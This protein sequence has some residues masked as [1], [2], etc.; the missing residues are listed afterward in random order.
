MTDTSSH[1]AD[2]L[3]RV[4]AARARWEQ[5]GTDRA[6]CDV[7]SAVTPTPIGT[8]HEFASSGRI[9]NEEVPVPGIVIRPPA[10]TREIRARIQEF[11][12]IRIGYLVDIDTGKLLGDCLDALVLAAED[13][14]SEGFGYRPVEIVVGMGRGLPRKAARHTVAAYEDLCDQGCIAVVG[15]YTTDGAMA[16]LPSMERRGVPC[17]STNGAKA[18]HSKYGFTLGN[19]GVSEES[20]IMADW[21][22]DQGYNRIGCIVEDSPGGAEYLHAFQL[23]ARFNRLQ[24]VGEAHCETTGEGLDEGLRALRDGGQVDVLVYCGYGYPIAMV[25]PILAEL[26]WDPPRIQSTAF[27]WYINEPSML[28]DFEGWVGID[29]IGDDEGDQGSPNYWP[30][31]ERY[32][33][34]F[35]RMARHA[36]IANS[37]DT[38][39]TIMMAITF[40]PLLTPEGMVS[41]LERITMLPTTVG[42]PGAYISFGTWDRKGYKGDFLTI[43]KVVDG[44]PRWHGSWT[45]R[46]PSTIDQQ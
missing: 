19:G 35:G 46:L 9:T 13:V 17:L 34:R 18:W 39:R 16:I 30:M 29:Q 33:A 37:Y 2:A 4:E 24:I 22:R 31:V 10:P 1:D 3:A 20:A 12:P 23:G 32:R 28:A 26:G 44:I 5:G 27:M 8:S 11:E 25:N 45:R 36:M 42:G 38:M 41:G 43:R 15:P 40:A 14:L 7:F 6:R 21:C